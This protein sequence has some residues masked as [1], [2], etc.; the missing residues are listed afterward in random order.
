MKYQIEL[1]R[2][3]G[4]STQIV[5]QV[6]VDEMSPQRAKTKASGLLSLY[7]GRGANVARVLNEKNEEL[8][9]L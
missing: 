9:K 3:F 2:E 8:Y 1:L 7:G 4:G 5:Y 6:T